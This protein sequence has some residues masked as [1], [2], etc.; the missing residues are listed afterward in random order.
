MEIITL[1]GKVTG[2][3]ERRIDKNGNHYLR[4]KVYCAG[5]EYNGQVKYTL[6][7]CF[8]YDTSLCDLKEGDTVFLSGDL[9]SSIKLDNNGKA[10]INYDV[11]VKNITKA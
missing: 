11:F 8:T 5:K 4:F 10:W 9:S 3:C 2:N 7:R 6:Y 1:S